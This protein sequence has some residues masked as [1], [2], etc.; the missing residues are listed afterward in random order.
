[1]W[2]HSKLTVFLA[3][4]SLS[5]FSYSRDL[6]QILWPRF[7]RILE[8]NI[9]SV[10]DTNPSRLGNID[11]RPHYVCPLSLSLSLSLLY[12]IVSP[13]QIT[14]RYAEF[15][16]ALVSINQS[17][18]DDQVDQC[19]L[20]LQGEVEN[21]ILR[22]AAEFPQRREQL[23]FLINNYD[24]MLSVLTV[25][26]SM[27]TTVFCAASCELRKLASY[28]QKLENICNSCGH[29]HDVVHVCRHK[30]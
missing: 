8:L 14:R 21:F 1:M 25:S 20:S 29:I 2:L 19:L 18:P 24:M 11:T 10:R 12:L 16:A 30:I 17:H 22:M 5:L 28:V 3:A 6:T 23:V 27:L 26:S 15:S 9:A 4:L 7:R 13:L